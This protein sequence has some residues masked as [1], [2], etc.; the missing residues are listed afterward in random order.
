MMECAELDAA[1]TA[2]PC[3]NWGALGFPLQA[4]PYTALVEFNTHHSRTLLTLAERSLEAGLAA[5]GAGG[6]GSSSSSS[7]SG[8]GSGRYVAR[9]ARGSG[10][11][12]VQPLNVAGGLAVCL[13][14]CLDGGDQ[15]RVHAAGTCAPE[16]VGEALAAVRRCVYVSHVTAGYCPRAVP[17]A[18]TVSVGVFECHGVVGARTAVL[19]V[20]L[21]SSPPIWDNSKQWPKIRCSTQPLLTLQ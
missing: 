17:V 1:T 8:G 11:A 14:A 13:A 9:D 16:A 7:A 18:A 19:L 2:Q 10:A 20:S 15:G 21:A 5:A 6:A 12:K 3:A 4:C